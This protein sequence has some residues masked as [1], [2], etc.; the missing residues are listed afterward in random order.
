MTGLAGQVVLVTGASSGIGAAAAELFAEAG[1]TVALAA[2]RTGQMEELVGRIAAAGGTAA[3]FELDVTSEGSIEAC[4]ASVVERFGR[5]DHAFNNAGVGATHKPIEDT[6]EAEYDLVQDVCLK[7]AFF[8]MK[9]EIRAMKGTGG[10]SIVNTASVGGRIGVPGSADYVA[11]KHG[12]IGLTKS[13]AMEAAPY[14]I[15][16]NVIAPGATATDMYRRWLPTAEDQQRVADRGLQKR[17]ASPREIAVYA[18][19][20]MRDA[21][22]STGNVFVCDGGM[23]L[24]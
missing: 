11:A 21:T 8:S 2:R 12:L 13:A 23:S 3:A 22:F 5:L 9:H 24:G 10:G 16:V 15:R 6:S 4:V 20:A 17:I 1:A 7:G 14:N 19:F 18:L